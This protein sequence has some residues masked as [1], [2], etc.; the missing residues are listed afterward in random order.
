MEE[1]P[2]N[3]AVT[4]RRKKYEAE[5]IKRVLCANSDTR[6]LNRWESHPGTGLSHQP[7][8]REER[9]AGRKIERKCHA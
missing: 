8:G 7:K 9:A 2:R 6:A 3:K 4:Y 5:E 1:A